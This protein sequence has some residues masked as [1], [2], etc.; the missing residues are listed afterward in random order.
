MP[1]R[2]YV[3]TEVIWNKKNDYNVD[4]ETVIECNSKPLCF[5]LNSKYIQSMIR[6][7][8]LR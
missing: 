7:E 8:S 6:L 2:P 4:N 5:T 1:F 3:L